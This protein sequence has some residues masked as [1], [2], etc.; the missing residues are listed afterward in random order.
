MTNAHK[1][2][3]YSIER[4]DD[5]LKQISR[6]ERKY[7]GQFFT[8][9]ETAMFMA[10]LFNYESLPEFVSILDAGAGSGI[11]TSAV[12]DRLCECENIKKISITC[13][14]TDPCILPVLKDVLEY[15]TKICNKK[16]S[17]V[18]VNSDFVLYF[19]KSFEENNPTL[20]FDLTIGNP[21]YKKILKSDPVAKAVPSIIY[22]AP[23]L[24]FIFTSIALHTIKS[25]GELVFIIPMSWTSGVYF[26]KFREYLLT[27]GKITNIH[28][29][30]SRDKVF[31]KEQVLQET[32]IIKVVKDINN[33]RTVRI[34]SSLANGDFNSSSTLNV[35]YS[36]VISG[37]EKYVFLPTTIRDIETI[38]K[39]NKYH[40]TFPEI[41]IKMKTGIVVDFRN[42]DLL[43]Q[44]QSEDCVPLFYSQN[45]KNGRVNHDPSGKKNDWIKTTKLGL[46]QKNKNYI[47]CKRFTA[48]EEKRR[49]QCGIYLARNF[50]EY[51]YIGT[52]NKINFVELNEDKEN[53][54]DCIYGIFALLNSTLFDLYYRI[55]NGSTQVNSSEINKIS[56]PPLDIVKKI[57]QRLIEEGELTTEIC[58][59]ILKEEAYE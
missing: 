43:C 28:L 24:Y 55:L 20:H 52:H 8:S 58:D 6:E 45:I 18:L 3:E 7:K 53:S 33:P 35:P 50:P 59:K 30:T 40:L 9:K 32:I 21:P 23:N 2:L 4:T 17:Y 1:F 11:L 42:K 44:T 29:F 36:L 14:E 46:I 51:K 54:L 57:G 16:L 31:T 48:K 38:K 19:S 27:T 37:T 34:T 10:D 47:F 13:F 5:Y 41:G 12:I 49:L 22:G 15:A 56:V 39:I 25:N 26:K